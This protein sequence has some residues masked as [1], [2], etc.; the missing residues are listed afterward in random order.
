MLQRL[1]LMTTLVVLAGLATQSL[2]DGHDTVGVPSGTYTNDPAHTSLTWRI[3]HMGLSDYTARINGVAIMLEFDAAELARSSVSAR[4][5]PMAVDTAYPHSDKDF[6]QEIAADERILNGKAFP[7]IQ[8]V[9]TRVR[10]TGPEAALIEGELTLLGVTHTV[11]L[12]AKLNGSMAEHPFAKVPALGFTATTTIDR[13]VFGLTF[14]SGSLLGDTID[15]VI[16]AE[17]LKQ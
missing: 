11:E 9:S 8:F 17:F 10:Q 12:N 13:T 3:D 6:N 7:E 16:Q 1:I 14:L 2:A 5:N 15:I 4:I